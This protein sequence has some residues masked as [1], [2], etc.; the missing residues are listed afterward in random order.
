[1]KYDHP[2]FRLLVRVITLGLRVRDS[3][4]AYL[5][6][7]GMSIDMVTFRGSTY[8]W[9]VNCP[10]LKLGEHLKLAACNLV[11]YKLAM[12]PVPCAG[13]AHR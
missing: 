13:F 2:S 1:M 5:S 11:L 6:P 12:Q 9:V 10:A 4:Q 8:W 7:E 3:S